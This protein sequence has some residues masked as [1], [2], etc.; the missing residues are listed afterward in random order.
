[1]RQA[2]FTYELRYWLRKPIT[3]GYLLA[4]AGL[5]FVVLIGTAGFFDPLPAGTAARSRFLNS[6]YALTELLFYF[7]KFFLFLLP[8]IVG[9]TVYKDYQGQ[10]HSLL[11][12]YPITKWSYAGGKLLS[13]GLVVLGIILAGCFALML[14]TQVP[15]LH[16]GAIGPHRPDAFL[17]PLL[18]LTLPNLLVVGLFCFVV[19]ILTRN[20]YAGFLLVIGLLLL[21]L[22]LE[23]AL[24]RQPILLALTDPFGQNT[25]AYLTRYWS[26]SDQNQL[27]LPL[28]GLLLANRAAWLLLAVLSWL[29]AMRHFSLSQEGIS[30]SRSGTKRPQKQAGHKLRRLSAKAHTAA[31]LQFGPA[32]ILTNLMALSGQYLRYLL[33]SKLLWVLALLAM[34]V[35]WFILSRVTQLEDMVLMPRT[36]IMLQA[37]AF[38]YTTIVLLLTF[39]FSGMLLHRERQAHMEQLLGVTAIPTGVPLLAKLLAL[40]ALQGLLL[41]LLMGTGIALQLHSG[42][43]DLELD[44]YLSQLLGPYWLQLIIWALI[45]FF[46]HS[47]VSSPY[48]GMFLLLMA[49]LGL[50]MLPDA[51]MDHPLLVFNPGYAFVYSDLSGF[52]HGLAAQRWVQGYWLLWG[53]LALLACY[54]LHQRAL[55]LP[56]LARWQAAQARWQ[57]AIPWLALAGIALLLAAG[58][59]IWQQY[60]AGVLPA[61]RQL[62]QA[63]QDF[64][65]RYSSLKRELVPHITHLELELDLY[66]SEARFSAAGEYLIINPHAVAIDTLLIRTGFDEETVLLP[67]ARLLPIAADSSLQFRLYQLVPTLQPGDSLRLAFQIR[68][69]ANTLFTQNTDV[70]GNGSFLKTGI[71]PRLGFPVGDQPPAPTAAGATALH[72]QAADADVLS[73]RITLSGPADQQLL[74]PGELLSS[75][76]EQGRRYQTYASEGASKLALTFHAGAYAQSGTRHSGI[77][78]EVLHAPAHHQRVEQMLGGIKTALDFNQARFGDYQYSSV[79][80]VEFPEQMGTYATMQGNL[81][82]TSERR[83]ISHA[84]SAVAAVD[85]SFYV[86]AHELT[87][88]WWGTQLT[89][90]H[91][92][93]AMLLTESITEYLSLQM[94]RQARGA[95]AGRA[96][97]QL[98]LERYLR[99]RA[100]A[101]KAEVP[102]S[103]VEPAQQYLAYGKGTLAFDALAM[104][105]GHDYLQSM[106]A[107][108]HTRYA[109]QAAPYATSLDLIGYLKAQSPD[110]L[111]A[112]ITELFEEVLT[113]DLQL[114]QVGWQQAAGGE[115]EVEVMLSGVEQRGVGEEQRKEPFSGWVSLACYDAADSLLAR[116]RLYLQSG[117]ASHTLWLEEPPARLVLDPELYYIDTNPDNNSYDWR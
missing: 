117:Q 34:L 57:G 2:I 85:I 12:S 27:A 20:Q 60:A 15:G 101:S 70:L 47:L 43:Y 91:A 55:A 28:S 68:S 18:V 74:A 103:L 96:F 22:L 97:K 48:V 105:L 81:M 1:M 38:F 17:Y 21:Q 78:L 79:R 31:P 25:L 53:L 95:T 51:G 50:G 41:L 69:K 106:L 94:Y 67:G 73:Y 82:P 64:E 114:E 32:Y 40:I 115:T 8:A 23:N 6:P 112:R 104:D 116:Q 83:F 52:G 62:E 71:L 13:A 58:V 56:W 30:W 10:V 98:Q 61:Q 76:L 3:Y 92:Q 35:V 44:L 37:P 93:G 36:R 46:T 102:L 14:A 109:G 84:D 80:V 19:V 42:Y 26:L 90:A 54:L 100:R 11:Y 108:F 39:I 4:F 63:L 77:D 24:A 59:H 87:H 45:S 72:Y 5:L 88:H 16:P 7:N 33:R 75:R 29:L 86:A 66:P 49:W 110:S 107:D 9:S 99:G 89:P 65:A 113:Y 111:H